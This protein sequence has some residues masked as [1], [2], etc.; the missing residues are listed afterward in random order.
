MDVTFLKGFFELISKMSSIF[1]S[2]SGLRDIAILYFKAL[3]IKN[4]L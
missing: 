2:T 3:P 4:A 1:P